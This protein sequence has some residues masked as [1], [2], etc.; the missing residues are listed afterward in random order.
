MQDIAKQKAAAEYALNHNKSL[1][2]RLRKKL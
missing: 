2:P 1:P